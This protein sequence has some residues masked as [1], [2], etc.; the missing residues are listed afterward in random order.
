MKNPVAHRAL[1]LVAEA[2][3]S[4]PWLAYDGEA[5]V[6]QHPAL[7]LLAQPNA[8]QSGPDFFEALYG[9][10]MLADIAYIEPLMLGEALRELHL[11]RPDRMSVVESRDGWVTG[12]DYR[13]GNVT[14]RLPAEAGRERAPAAAPEAVLHPLDDHLDFPPLVRRSTCTM[15]QAS[16]TRR[17]STIRRAL[18]LRWSSSR[19][20]ADR[21]PPTSTSG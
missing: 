11:L 12:Y 9:H 4:V 13:A 19:R 7:T 3:A 14:R 1:R 8:C 18:P 16:G 6:S 20:K 17:C 15:P 21:L 10:L 2:A 5:E